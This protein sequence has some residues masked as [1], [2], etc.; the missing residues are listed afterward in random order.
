MKSLYGL[1]AAF[2][3]GGRNDLFVIEDIDAMS[4]QLNRDKESA[5]EKPRASPLHEI[6]NSMDGMQTPDGLKFIVTTNHLDRL[7]PALV[8]PGRIDEVLEIGPLPLESAR[9]MFCAFYGREGITAY[10]PQ[11][12]AQLQ[13]LFSTVEA[14]KAE[15]ELARRAKA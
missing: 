13:Q 10:A 14:E 8:R 9:A 3:T 1:G 15:A 2:K 6:L 4:A 11:T 12:G 5:D 7:D